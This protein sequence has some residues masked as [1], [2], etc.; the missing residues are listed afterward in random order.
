[1]VSIER[2]RP[3]MLGTTHEGVMDFFP[4]DY[5]ESPSLFKRGDTYFAT[6]GSCC[7]GCSEGGGITVF[8]APAV[9]G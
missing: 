7:C 9:S 2:L 4:D 6:Y 8:T 5:V 3:D 1:M